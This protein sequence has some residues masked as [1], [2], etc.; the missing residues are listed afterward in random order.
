VLRVQSA[1]ANGAEIDVSIDGG[2]WY[3]E[4]VKQRRLLL[5]VPTSSRAPYVP[6]TGW[7]PIASSKQMPPAMFNEGHIYH[8]IIEQ[9]EQTASVTDSEA[10]GEDDDAADSATAKPLRRGRT[11]FSSG[12]VQDLFVCDTVSTGDYFFLKGRVR[13]SM[14][15]GM[16][17]VTMTLSLNSGFIVDATCDC[18]ASALGRCSHVTGVMFALID[19]KANGS[20]CTS[21]KCEWNVGRKRGNQPSKVQDANYNTKAK[22]K[23]SALKAFDPRPEEFRK[24]DIS[25]DE[26]NNFISSLALSGSHNAMWLSVIPF[27]YSDYDYSDDDYLLLKQKVSIINT[28]LH[29]VN[30]CSNIVDCKHFVACSVVTNSALQIVD[31]QSC[32]SWFA[33]RYIRITASNCYDVCAHTDTNAKR[34]L[35]RLLWDPMVTTQAM[36]YGKDKEPVAL[37]DFVADI[38]AKIP[39]F[40]AHPT[41]F[42]VNVASPQLGCSPDGI[43]VSGSAEI[44]LVEVKCPCMGITQ[45]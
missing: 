7:K 33:E 29:P 22:R 32:D 45:M 39:A 16:Y 11:Y 13:Q 3:D 27:H 1:I 20:S 30:K 15:D 18:K 37:S 35:K 24:N 41:G 8:Y 19:F 5:S 14:G 25:S 2:I 42:W 21:Q 28:E 40:D 38:R 6:I 23:P 31:S 26:S 12:H 4:K 36:Q 43:A 44:A 17:N 9:A 34:L 10:S